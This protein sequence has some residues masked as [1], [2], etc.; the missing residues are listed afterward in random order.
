MRIGMVLVSGVQREVETKWK[1][2]QV[3]I[4]QWKENSIVVLKTGEESLQ[5]QKQDTV[6]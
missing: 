1:D 3:A 6:C 4:L 2:L 5:I